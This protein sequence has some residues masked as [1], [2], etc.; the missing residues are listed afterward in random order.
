MNTFSP[1]Q[2]AE[3]NIHIWLEHYG[4]T[5][6]SG[7]K[8]E[9]KDRAFLWDIFQD[10]S[11]FQV[12]LKPPQIG[13]TTLEIL[14]SLWV[15]KNKKRDIIYT[16]PTQGDVQDMAGG[17][18]NRLI[19]QNPI[20]QEWVKDYDTT[21]QKAV[22]D[23]IIFYRGCVDEKTE[24]L[25]ERGWRLFNEV[26]KGDKLPS[27]NI[28]T[29]TVEMDVVKDLSIFSVN[30]EMIR[31]KSRQ[32]DQL[33]TADHRCVVSKRKFNGKKGNLR[34][35][36]AHEMIGK[37]TFYIPVTHNPIR[38]KKNGEP[39]FFKILGWVIGDGSYWTKR[40]KS[41]YIKKDGTINPSIY[42][43]QKVC[44]IQSKFC[45]ELESDLDNAGIKFYK[46]T[47]NN[48]CFRYEI[49]SMDSKKI[50]KYIPDKKLSF[51]LIFNASFAERLS[52][53]D[54]L[55][56]SDGNNYKQ[57]IFYQNEGVTVDVFQA[58][59]VLLGKTSSVSKTR[60]NVTVSIK[61]SYYAN[62]FSD[63]VKYSGIVWCPTTKNGTI[64]TRRNGVVSV[65]GQTF[66]RKQAMMVPSSLNIHDEVDA[67]DG[68]I[69]EQY[70]TR[71][72]ARADGWRWY[73]SHPS[74]PDYGVDKYWQ[75]SDQ[76][77]WFIKCPLCNFEQFLSWPDSIDLERR[78]FQ[79][80][81][82]KTEIK[83]RNKGRW[84]QKYPG[85]KFSGYWVSQLMCP[86]IS[87]EKILTDFKEKSPEYFWNYVLG[88]PYS[89]GD[90]KLTKEQLFSGLTNT[91]S[92]PPNDERIILGVDTGLKLDFVLGDEKYGLFFH[93]DTDK[94]ETLDVIM[95][96]W[97]NC[98][99]VMDAGGD[100]I[101]SRQF[102][103]RYP[104]RVFLAY[105]GENRKTNEL[106]WW[107]QNEEQGSVTYD[108][109]RV[110]QLI[111]DEFRTKR[112]P[113]QGKEEDWWEYWLDWKNMSRIKIIDDKTGMLRG[114]K[115]VRNGRNH[116]ASATLFWRIGMMRFS[117]YDK[118]E[119]LGKSEKIGSLGYESKD[120]ATILP[121][122]NQ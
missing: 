84:L 42:E 35:F 4:I 91:L 29:N 63:F 64:F 39:Y 59:L 81:K 111:V 97:K 76:K 121:L 20:L 27:L 120:G 32:I 26:E 100:L 99:A 75:D 48:N 55:M 122:L 89:G 16:L 107:G 37:S 46:K 86:W 102:Y 118:G 106:A 23:N 88:L 101:G 98:I 92:V 14:K 78:C 113:L 47:H 114:I 6:E 53:Y 33:V 58:L 119:I 51:P 31:I 43:T 8:L 50:R 79:C 28:K 73:F 93:G 115:W 25:T 19:A 82:C 49:S 21:N 61:Q 70:E 40:D 117:T 112:I 24:V 104:G 68:L 69:I 13:M 3:Y 5:N 94:Y 38:D 62:V 45:D 2:L 65:T 17:K 52:L 72:Q 10:M 18:I 85:K 105:A 34:I 56:Q 90:S 7:I 57:S 87:V 12:V 66:T 41:S 9:F 108:L 83:E 15:A 60:K 96:R 95:K 11:P 1:E 74:V 71:L 80:K 109:N 77:H 67:S 22:G 54:G 30:E 110:W 103:E 116:R 36:R 44:I